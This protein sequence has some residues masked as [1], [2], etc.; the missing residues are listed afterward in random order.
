MDLKNKVGVL[1][2]RF[3][4]LKMTYEALKPEFSE[5]IK[6]KNIPL[7]ERWEVFLAAPEFIKNSAPYIQDFE[8]DGL[9]LA[10]FDS[11]FYYEKCADVLMTDV[12][13]DLEDREFCSEEAVNLLKEQILEAN[14]HSFCLDW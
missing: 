14:L 3:H 13:F 10:W 11:P 8:V 4:N 2:E 12:I 6:D 1:N 9:E 7:S 5:Y